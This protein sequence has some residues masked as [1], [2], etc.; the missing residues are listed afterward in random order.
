MYIK[1]GIDDDGE[2]IRA[3]IPLCI[4][5]GNGLPIFCLT[6][7]LKLHGRR[8]ELGLRIHKNH[9]R[10][11]AE[12]ANSDDT[13]GDS[14][15]SEESA[16]CVAKVGAKGHRSRPPRRNLPPPRN[17]AAAS[18]KSMP[19]DRRKSSSAPPMKV[20]TEKDSRFKAEPGPL[21]PVRNIPMPPPR[22]RSRSRD[23]YYGP[24][25]GGR[26]AKAPKV[27]AKA[28]RSAASPR[29]EQPPLRSCDRLQ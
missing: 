24:S 21:A 4:M 14:K 25:E 7:M 9:R 17:P 2:E 8:K 12:N 29:A 16:D 27:H 18:S 28:Q 15:T 11:V 5:K 10:L 6:D 23:G 22:R 13:S 20:K 1:L 19:G 3:E 26:L